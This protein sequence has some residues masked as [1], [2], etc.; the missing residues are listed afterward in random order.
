MWWC[1]LKRRNQDGQG[2]GTDTDVVQL[3]RSDRRA[4]LFV[5]A[6][7]AVAVLRGPWQ[8]V[9]L[10]CTCLCGSCKVPNLAFF[11]SRVLSTVVAI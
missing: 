2:G 10:G 8:R 11:V 3:R 1:D 5:R 6:T 4:R 7:D 9:R